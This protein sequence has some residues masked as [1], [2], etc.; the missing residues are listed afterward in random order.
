M[1]F[2]ELNKSPKRLLTSFNPQND[3]REIL[4]ENGFA[5]T[6]K[7]SV[8]PNLAKLFSQILSFAM[9]IAYTYMDLNVK[10]KIYQPNLLRNTG[11]VQEQEIHTDYPPVFR[12]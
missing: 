11:F 1:Q 10:Y 9:N 3:S 8:Y 7:L 6:C 12:N 4:H 5:G 2:S